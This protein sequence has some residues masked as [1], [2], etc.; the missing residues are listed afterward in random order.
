MAILHTQTN[1]ISV[2][3][4]CLCK[5][6]IFLRQTRPNNL[7]ARN[8]SWMYVFDISKLNKEENA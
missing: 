3:Y 1:F 2:L 4:A 7:I 5:T 6:D 8:R